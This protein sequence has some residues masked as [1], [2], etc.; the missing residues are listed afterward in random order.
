M[1]GGSPVP[2]LDRSGVSIYYEVVEGSGPPLVLLHGGMGS[3]EMWRFEGYVDA[4]REAFRLV[5][6][7]L[8][9]HGRSSAPHDPA[10]YTVDAFVADLEAILD[11]LGLPSAALC[12]FSLGGSVALA[13]AARYPERCDAVVT[14]DGDPRDAESEEDQDPEDDSAEWADRFEREGM[15]WAAAA[16]EAE[17]RPGWARMVKRTDPAAMVAL[18]RSLGESTWARGL[19]FEDLAPP[20]IAILTEETVGQQPPWPDRAQVVVI[21][22]DHVGVVEHQEI[23]WPLVRSLA[24]AAPALHRA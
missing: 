14:L 6:V 11:A 9:G 23:V 7:D 13:F 3:S 15:D 17:G 21:P 12:G 16:L 4:L 24:G 22:T 8:R 2:T 10:A 18:F 1:E 20:L 19:R 5:L